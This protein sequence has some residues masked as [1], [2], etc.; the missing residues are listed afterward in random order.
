MSDTNQQDLYQQNTEL[1]FLNAILPYLQSKNFVDIG[2]EKGSFARFLMDKGFNGQLFEPLPKHYAVL[3]KIIEHTN[4][5]VFNYAIDANDGEASFHIACDENGEI[6]DYFHSLQLME[7]DSQVKHQKSIPV[8]CRSLDSLVAEKIVPQI[9]GILKTDTEGN[10]LRVLQGMSKLSAEIIM[11]EFFTKGLYSGWEQATPEGLIAE[12]KR[13]GFGEYIAIIRHGQDEIIAYKP[14]L[15]LER[16]W[17]NLI[18][19]KDELAEQVT[20]IV[21]KINVSKPNAAPHTIEKPL[22]NESLVAWFQCHLSDFLSTDKENI[23]LD[24]GGYGDLTKSMLITNKLQK[25]LV[26]ADAAISGAKS[27]CSFALDKRVDIV[28][29]IKD[30]QIALDNYINRTNIKENIALIKIDTQ[31][32]NLLILKGAKKIIKNNNCVVVIKLIFI[33]LFEHPAAPYSILQYLYEHGYV[34]AGLFN[35]HY[36]TDGWLA[37]ADAIF[38]PRDRTEKFIEPFVSQPN[39]MELNA[40]NAMLRKTCEERLALINRLHDEAGR[41]LGIINKLESKI[42][43]KKQ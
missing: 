6:H 39:Y 2:A 20:A 25:A 23:I 30:G 37:F 14:T 41:R 28:G 13:K 5:Q 12:A 40:E 38:V 21:K 42:W 34:M 10:D 43:K 1:E 17:G 29:P 26:F 7:G 15:F 4:S 11:C 35:Q 16:Q 36:T 18:F 31:C 27:N 22:P 9:V 24:V 32:D 8:T 3:K 19:F 33:D